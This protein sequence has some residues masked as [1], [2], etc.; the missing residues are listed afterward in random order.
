MS[1]LLSCLLVTAVVT[2]LYASEGPPP[3]AYDSITPIGMQNYVLS[4]PGLYLDSCVKANGKLLDLQN[5][6]GLSCNSIGDLG[7]KVIAPFIPWTV[8]SVFIQNQSLGEEGGLGTLLTK[9]PAGLE[10]FSIEVEPEGCLHLRDIRAL[11]ENLRNFVHLRILTLKNCHIDRERLE[12][13]R[14]VLAKLRVTSLNLSS[15][16]ISDINMELL[17]SSLPPNLQNLLLDN[18]V[19]DDLKPLEQAGWYLVGEDNDVN[20]HWMKIPPGFVMFTPTSP[21]FWQN[22]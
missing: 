16:S 6:T 11:A 1:K 14:P 4:N 2:S 10:I 17:I 3:P 9:L 5:P 7:L 8:T 18:N 12:I 13:L 22:L 19:F 20:Q 15:N 21:N